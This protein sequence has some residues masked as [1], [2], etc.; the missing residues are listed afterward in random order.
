MPAVVRKLDIGTVLSRTFRTYADQATLLIPAAL[1]VFLPIAIVSGLA[2]SGGGIL[3]TLLAVLLSTLGGVLYQGMVVEAA[4]D[5]LDG[6]RDQTVGGLIR[7]AVP[8][9]VPLLV[10]GLIVSI[11]TTLGLILV[12]VGA[13]LVAAIFA[14]VAPV[15]VI[16]RTGPIGALGRSVELVRPYFLPVLGV[17]VVVFLINLVASFVLRALISAIDEGIVGFSVAS[18]ITQTFVAPIAALAAAVLYFE[19]KALHGEPLGVEGPGGQA[20]GS[21]GAG[22]AHPAGPPPTS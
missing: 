1:V 6:R 8:V 15:V 16:E 7:S 20:V 13:I 22:A 4:R 11:A 21:P 2:L 17:V 19:L 9:I 5:M 12:I 3:G 14:V 10:A 18:L